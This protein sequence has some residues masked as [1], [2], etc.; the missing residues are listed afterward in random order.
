MPALI[1]VPDAENEVVGSA[2]PFCPG[3][4]DGRSILKSVRQK[5]A[6][7]RVIVATVNGRPSHPGR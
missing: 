3:N 5:H 7:D 6:A 2:A 1:P 4:H